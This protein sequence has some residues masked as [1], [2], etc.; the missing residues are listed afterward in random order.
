MYRTTGGTWYCSTSPSTVTPARVSAPAIR[1]AGPPWPSAAKTSP[2]AETAL[3]TRERV[4]NRSGSSKMAELQRR[5]IQRAEHG[6]DGGQLDVG[7]HASA[8]ERASVGSFDL[9]VGD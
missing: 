1:P 5:A 2:A 8:P 4:P 3:P 6:A 7:I 9:D